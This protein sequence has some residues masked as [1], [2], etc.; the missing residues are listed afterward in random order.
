MAKLFNT[1]TSKPKGKGKEKKDTKPIIF[2]KESTDKGI[3]NKVSRYAKLHEQEESIRAEKAMLK[4]DLWD[5]AKREWLKLF[6]K[7]KKRETIIVLKCENGAEFQAQSLDTYKKVEEE[8]YKKLVKAYGKDIAEHTQVW[9][10][11]EEFLEKHM[12]AI[13]KAIM[14]SDEIPEEDKKEE[15]IFDIN[16]RDKYSIAK[17]TV[18][19]LLYYGKKKKSNSPEKVFNDI[20]PTIQIKSR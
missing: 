8:D 15:V 3:G 2:L 19:K 17:G 20:K 5:V 16:D 12:K 6:K 9:K 13:E 4:Q 18:D 1:T 7:N 14:S 10:F 11:R